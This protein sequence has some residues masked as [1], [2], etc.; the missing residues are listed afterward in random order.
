MVKK[1]SPQTLEVQ[2]SIHGFIM[3]VTDVN[4]PGDEEGNR[5]ASIEATLKA[6][7]NQFTQGISKDFIV[8]TTDKLKNQLNDYQKFQ[9]GKFEWLGPL[10]ILVTL[11]AALVATDFRDFL[12]IKGIFWETLFIFALLSSLIWLLYLIFK[13]IRHREQRDLNNLIQKIKKR[14]DL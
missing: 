14:E 8:T 9:V 4:F 5:V 1:H 7:L 12:N 6:E 13:I 11:I 10:G 3:G 2:S